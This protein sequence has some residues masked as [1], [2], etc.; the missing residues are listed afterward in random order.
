MGNRAVITTR[1]NFE[2]GGIGIYLHWNGGRD[3]VEGFLTYCK[4]QGY[5]E[6]TSD[7]YGWLYLATTIGNYFGD[8]LSAGIDEVKYLDCD[9][10]DNG[11]YFIDG[12]DI[13]GREYF[14]GTEQ[15]SYPL[16]DMLYR[17]NEKQPEHMRLS[18]EEIKN[19]VFKPVGDLSKV[20]A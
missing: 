6:P 18:D 9:N 10:W 12:W 3:S 7:N 17:I 16:E 20:L 11:V 19:A 8:G 14:S 1:E 2:N 4:L 13:V 15:D 5:R